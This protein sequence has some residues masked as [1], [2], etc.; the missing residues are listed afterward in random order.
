MK[1]SCSAKAVL[2]VYLLIS[3]CF[4]TA[5]MS[6]EENV[7]DLALSISQFDIKN[8]AGAMW[9]TEEFWAGM[10]YQDKTS[11][12]VM[13]YHM[14]KIAGKDHLFFSMLPI[15]QEA[16]PFETEGPAVLANSDG[17]K[18]YE[19]KVHESFSEIMPGLMAFPRID[20]QG[21]AVVSDDTEKLTL[22]VKYKDGGEEGDFEW[23]LPL[24][25]PEIVEDGKEWLAKPVEKTESEMTEGEILNKYLPPVLRMDLQS[26]IM[27]VYF[28]DEMSGLLMAMDPDVKK[29]PLLRAELK[30]IMSDNS[31]FF[32]GT[33]K[34]EKEE[35]LV[36]MAESAR[37]VGIDGKKY[38]MD[39]KTRNDFLASTEEEGKEE[40]EDEPFEFM[41]FPQL[42]REG[43]V[44]LILKDSERDREI[45]F[46][47][48]M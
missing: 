3:I 8:G 10:A 23:G 1:I 31:I 26:G 48:E 5:A 41:F 11:D 27:A 18:V 28:T 33:I 25:Y 4:A 42:G 7:E 2:A 13:G 17:V 43:L 24:I 39:I 12:A 44:E 9:W 46:K 35:R 38:S 36:A 16:G 40:E 14:M 20:S 15:D 32:V 6:Q 21:K 19:A 29:N 37:A 34:N 22:T 45:S 30:K 47:W